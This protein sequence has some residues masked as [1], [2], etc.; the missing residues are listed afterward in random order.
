MFTDYEMCLDMGQRFDP[1][2]VTS[3]PR[4]SFII[5]IRIEFLLLCLSQTLCSFSPVVTYQYICVMSVIQ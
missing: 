5:C 4:F 2:Y 3:S 1:L